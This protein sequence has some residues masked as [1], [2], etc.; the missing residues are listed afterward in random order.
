MQDKGSAATTV[1]L[2]DPTGPEPDCVT[3]PVYVPM[4]DEVDGE[5]VARL[6]RVERFAE[7]AEVRLRRTCGTC[8]RSSVAA[9]ACRT[10]RSR[11][12]PLPRTVV[13]AAG[14]SASAVAGLPA[15]SPRGQA[16]SCGR[17]PGERF[18]EETSSSA[19][20]APASSPSST[21]WRAARAAG[22]CP[23]DECPK[24]G[25]EHSSRRRRYGWSAGRMFWFTWKVFSG[26]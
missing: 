3:L 22:S 9:P 20:P 24:A 15:G 10:T 13:L 14:R 6:Q 18:E 19:P 23:T 8:R 16:W 7:T 5:L 4:T 17:C 2:G 25:V 12:N 11:A 1:R 21:P 26:S